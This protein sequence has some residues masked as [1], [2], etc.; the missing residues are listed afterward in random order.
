M[1]PSEPM[2]RAY[3]QDVYALKN[4]STPAEFEPAILGFNGEYDN[5]RIIGIDQL[6]INKVN[7]NRRKLIFAFLIIQGMDDHHPGICP[8]RSQWSHGYHI[9]H[10]IRGSWVQ[11]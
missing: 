7:V 8:S 5:H 4:P 1:L 10:W 6:S 11:T 9:C 3:T 2:R